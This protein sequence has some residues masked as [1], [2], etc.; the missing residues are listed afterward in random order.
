MWVC[1][2]TRVVA[3]AVWPQSKRRKPVSG[4]GD[5]SLL[6]DQINREKISLKKGKHSCFQRRR[7]HI[8]G[9]STGAREKVVPPPWRCLEV[10]FPSR[11][12]LNAFS[13]HL[14]PLTTT[15]SPY[16][17]LSGSL[18]LFSATTVVEPQSDRW[19]PMV[20]TFLYAGLE[21]EHRIHWHIRGGQSL[22]SPSADLHV[23]PN[24]CFTHRHV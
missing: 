23:R 2:D 10:Y 12:V 16:R 11:D 19:K 17:H 15:T 20:T 6:R 9:R 7:Q 22:Q 3:R 14:P 8:G 13:A 1:A 21:N 24:A 5:G 4:P 18:S